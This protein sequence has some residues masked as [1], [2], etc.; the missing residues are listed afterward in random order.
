M[1]TDKKTKSAKRTKQDKTAELAKIAELAKANEQAVPLPPTIE[2]NPQFAQAYQLLEAGKSLFI[3]GRAGTGKSTLL[4]HYLSMSKRQNGEKSAKNIA[5]VAPTGVAALNVGGQTIHSFFG[6]K[7]NITLEQIKNIRDKGQKAIYQA[8]DMLIIDEISMVRADLLDCVEKFLRLNTGKPKEA[9][10]GVQVV[11]IGDLYQLPPVVSQGE[12]EMFTTRYKAPHF[13]QAHCLQTLSWEFVELEKIYRQSDDDFI[14]LL[15]A[16]RN[17]SVTGDDLDVLNERYLPDFVPPPGEFYINLTTTNA[18]SDQINNQELAKITGREYL[19]L[20]E[21]EGD[22]DISYLPTKERLS[23]KRGAQVMLLNNDQ[24]GRWV[25]GTVGQVQRVVMG[26]EEGE[27]ETVIVKLANGA[28][29]EVYPFTWELFRY[30][31]E[32]GELLAEA[33]GSFTQFPLRLAFAITIHK[34]QGKTF[35]RVIV[36]LERGIFSHGQLYVALSRCTSL[37]GLVLKT[38]ISPRHLRLDYSVPKFL[39]NL[40]YAR[41]RQNLSLE[42]KVAM[43]KA[44]ISEKKE[45]EMV[46]LKAKDEKS[47]RRII[48]QQIGMME[49]SGHRFLGLNAFCLKR[50]ETRTFNVER[51]LSL[52]RK[53]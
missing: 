46:Y 16:I 6:F 2:I 44:A 47:T 39:T 30:R 1:S 25:N 11:M 29:V 12:A 10:G 22:F 37:T 48:P 24:R 27:V 33:V 35:E 5:V 4:K 21:L 38:R 51:I 15:N 45:L 14:H 23:I 53:D 40:Q 19:L 42:E 50:Q 17:A 18:R 52:E 26:D 43:L 28:T 20:G 31:V 7:P 13:F 36:D 34:S 41:A 9:F 49:F 8:L 32:N 3:T